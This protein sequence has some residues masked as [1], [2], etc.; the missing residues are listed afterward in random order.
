MATVS[1]DR[2]DRILDGVSRCISLAGPRARPPGSAVYG[3]G[4]QE[5]YSLPFDFSF[6]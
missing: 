5:K 1:V 6:M 3:L 4:V 2:E